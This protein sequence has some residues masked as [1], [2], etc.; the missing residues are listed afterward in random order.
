MSISIKGARFWRER[1]N[2]GALFLFEHLHEG[3]ENPKANCA[4][5]NRVDRRQER[6]CARDDAV[7]S[8]T[9]SSLFGQ[10]HPTRRDQRE[11]HQPKI[12]DLVHNY[13]LPLVLRDSPAAA[14]SA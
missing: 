5:Y 11:S 12:F 8:R 1:A 13:F 9:R 14:G 10:C 6:A 3:D 4:N 2:S 7:N